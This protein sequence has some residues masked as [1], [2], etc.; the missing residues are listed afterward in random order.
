MSSTLGRVSLLR[1]FCNATTLPWRNETVLP[2]LYARVKNW[3]QCPRVAEKPSDWSQSQVGN[4]VMLPRAITHRVILAWRRVFQEAATS[5]ADVHVCFSFL[6]L[7]QFPWSTR[8]R[9]LPTIITKNSTSHTFIYSAN[10]WFVL[11][12]FKHNVRTT[13]ISKC[14]QHC[15]CWPGFIPTPCNPIC[16]RTAIS[17]SSVAA[18]E[19]T[20]LRPVPGDWT[21][22]GTNPFTELRVALILTSAEGNP[23]YNTFERWWAS[24]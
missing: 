23:Q 4:N 9:K 1:Q 10:V 8:Q 17:T 3:R 16:S 24:A 2:T 20:I 14:K 12:A 5:P 18:A 13:H 19:R 6:T 21:D 15:C 22:D 11:S 7:P